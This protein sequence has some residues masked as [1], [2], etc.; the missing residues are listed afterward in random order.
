MVPVERP[1]IAGHGDYT[2]AIALRLAR[3]ARRPPREIAEAV[4]ARLRLDQAVSGVDVAAGGFLNI[5]LASDARGEIARMIVRAGDGYV[6]DTA[7]RDTAARGV[8]PGR[9]WPDGDND[10][11][12]RRD[13]DDHA[14]GVRAVTGST[15]DPT[16]LADTGLADLAD[17]VSTVGTDAARYSLARLPPGSAGARDI[18]LIDLDVITRQANGNPVFRVQYAHTRICLLL[19]NAGQLGLG[20]DVEGADV[21][22]LTHPREGDLLRALGDLP[23]AVAAAAELW[24]PYRVARYLEELADT[25]HRFHGVCEVLPRGNDAAGALTGARLLLADAT[26]IVLAGGLH[27]LGVSAPTRM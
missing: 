5:R 12:G 14:G 9:P 17:L 27:L 7:A 10:H 8:T 11:A 19:R 3:P 1:R 23:R 4:A 20:V 18:D 21:S 22:L 15:A 13:G 25:Y 2:T 26:R 6:R 16:D 24:A